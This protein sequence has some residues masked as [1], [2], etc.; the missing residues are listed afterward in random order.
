VLL[1]EIMQSL[2]TI[3]DT[4]KLAVRVV[5]P[6]GTEFCGRLC[7]DAASDNSAALNTAQVAGMPQAIGFMSST[8][9]GR[10]STPL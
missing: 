9:P 10:S 1:L 5:V 6:A 4:M 8:P 2:S 3:T 7:A